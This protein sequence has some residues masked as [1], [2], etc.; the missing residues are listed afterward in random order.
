MTDHIDSKEHRA[1]Y[2]YLRDHDAKTWQAFRVF[3]EKFP[4]A[5]DSIVYS[6]IMRIAKEKHGVSLFGF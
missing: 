4:G 1:P 6:L 3:N 5:S 2:F